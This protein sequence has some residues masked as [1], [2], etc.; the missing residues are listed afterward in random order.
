MSNP[1]KCCSLL[2]KLYFNILD[3]EKRQYV[4][5]NVTANALH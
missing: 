5:L 2:H 4:I 3:L 1:V